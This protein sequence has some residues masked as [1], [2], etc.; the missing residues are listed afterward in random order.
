MMSFLEPDASFSL[1]CKT[2]GRVGVGVGVYL[3]VFLSLI[4][5]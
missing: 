3:D 1:Q 5:A 2:A 4:R